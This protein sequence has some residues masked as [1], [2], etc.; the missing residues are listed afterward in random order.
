MTTNS[1]VKSI[2]VLTVFAIFIASKYTQADEYKWLKSSNYD[3]I[4]VYTSFSSCA[5]AENQL[6]KSLEGV[7]LR[8]RMQAFISKD[9]PIISVI[10]KEGKFDHFLRHKLVENKKI[11]LRVDA[12]CQKYDSVYIY[13]FGI[14][15]AILDEY[16]NI[17]LHASPDHG[18]AGI[19][20]IDGINTVFR[21]IVEDAVANYLSANM[22]KRN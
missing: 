3:N 16:G 8:T 4:F 6:T 13:R 19:N 1:K 5:I 22:Q 7:L 20:T 11:F 15:F 21:T 18:A 2:I 10:N 14:N 9:P 17:L 12:Q